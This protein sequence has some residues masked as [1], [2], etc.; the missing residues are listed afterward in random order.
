MKYNTLALAAVASLASASPLQKRQDIDF[1]AYKAQPT[2]SDVAAP[3]GFAS[4]TSVASYDP[5]SVAV[6]AAADITTALTVSAAVLSL[7][8]I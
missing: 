3:V 6:S 1:A 8:H 2:L 5:T 7:I 4:V